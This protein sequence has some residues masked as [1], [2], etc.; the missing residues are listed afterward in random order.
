MP[1]QRPQPRKILV[2]LLISMILTISLPAGTANATQTLSIKTQA[3]TFISAAKPNTNFGNLATLRSDASPTEKIY[4]RF[5]VR[6]LSGRTIKSARI[7][8]R[9]LVTSDSGLVLKPVANT[10][11]GE[12]TL[13]FRNA[14]P[15]GT[16]PIAAVTSLSADSW[17][18]F[19]VTKIITHEGLY[20]FA[21]VTRSTKPIRLVSRSSSSYYPRLILTLETPDPV[22]VGA[23]DI[24][25]CASS[26]DE[27]TAKL[28]DALPNAAVFTAG[29]NAYPGGSASDYANCYEPSW[30]RFKTR[31]RPT[32]GNHEY[33]SLGA[34]PYYAYFGS[35]AGTA[36]K[37]YYSYE[38]GSWH[39]VVLNSEIDM[40][41]GSEQEKWLRQDLSSH[42]TLCTLAV[43]HRPLFSSSSVHGN[44]PDVKPLWQALYQQHVEVVVN[45]HD[46]SYERFSPQDANGS[47]NPNGVR[48]FVA[49]MGGYSHY[50]MGVQLPNSQLYN[51]DTYG[52]IQF[53]LH[54]HSY[55]W[56]F[57]PEA[58]KTFTDSGSSQCVP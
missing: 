53:T 47:A 10:T 7:V 12:N 46:H 27:A 14:P 3:D 48:E 18:S 35:A 44:N 39:I 31:T 36:E 25:G 34:A 57:I 30:G 42:P 52:V 16:N 11:W 50:S 9:S 38:L 4:L 1:N 54:P 23:G 40:T 51:G 26:G 45:G 43:W 33:V 37:G 22:L 20:S 6:G 17:V 58:G 29:D 5:N 41:A 21:L 55:D 19:P 2:I 15:I 13:T 8:V 28:V 32:A 49:G 24:A 56:Q